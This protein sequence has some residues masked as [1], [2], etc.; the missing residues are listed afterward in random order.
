MIA[1]PATVA[2]LRKAL[3]DLPAD[4]RIGIRDGNHL[5]LIQCEV[6]LVTETANVVVGT[7]ADDHDL[8]LGAGESEALAFS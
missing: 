1:F 3:A 6:V 2:E 5:D 4:T 8:H 7:E